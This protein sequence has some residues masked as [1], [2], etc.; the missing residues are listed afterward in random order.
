M[1]LAEFPANER[2]RVAALYARQL[3]DS[4]PEER[5]DRISRLAVSS[6]DVPVAYVAFMDERRQYY[7]SICGVDARENP[8]ETALCSH[9]LL[10]TDG[11]V[12]ADTL[13]EPRFCDNPNV[14]G[15]P[16]I[17][18]YMGYPLRTPDGLAIG[19]FCVMDFQPRQMST[20]QVEAFRDLAHWAQNEVNLMDI[21][22]LQRELLE[23]RAQLAQRSAF[24][25]EVL[26]RFLTHQVADQLLEH[27]EGL[28][29]GGEEREVSVLMSDL[30]GFTDMSE[31]LA[32]DQ[33]V[34]LLNRY[35]GCMT[36]VIA[37]RQGTIDEF[38]GD[39]IL[40]IFGAPL[41]TEDHAQQAVACALE[42]QLAMEAFNA[43]SRA[44]GVEELEMG[45]AINTGRVVVGNIGSSARMKYGVV[46]SPVNLTAR[47]QGFS[48]GHQVL[49]SQSTL[50]RLG[51]LARVDG[52][53]RVKVKGVEEPVCIYDVGALGGPF[54]L[55]LPQ[56]GHLRHL[57]PLT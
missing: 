10:T 24:I 31:R 52:H 46:G 4:P 23:S 19:T 5:F 32:P 39:A 35:L 13:L 50:Q 15:H 11:I 34:S 30:R 57:S 27:P 53:L 14:L 56:P 21:I 17:R 12:A 16:H 2:E 38:I 25:R 36:D 40:V 3:M 1:P 33:I 37:A 41:E 26:G 18:F 43:E 29:L 9:T 44:L 55:A 54:G 8:R 22:E 49:V 48:L 28:K 20:E 51:G 42:M 47:I 7:K 6:L 45:I